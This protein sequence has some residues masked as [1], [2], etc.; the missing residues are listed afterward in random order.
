[1]GS[2]VKM[3]G[4]SI[5]L[6]AE[7]PT[8]L[9]PLVAGISVIL[10]VVVAVLWYGMR[11]VQQSDGLAPSRVDQPYEG[12]ALS[13]TPSGDPPR[14]LVTH[15]TLGLSSDLAWLKNRGEMPASL[16]PQSNSSEPI[17]A[18]VLAAKVFATNLPATAAPQ[19]ENSS[20]QE[21]M[22]V[23]LPPAE[24]LAVLRNSF[25][26]PQP[27]AAAPSPSGRPPRTAVLR[28]LDA[29]AT[30][31]VTD[32]PVAGPP[33]AVTLA[34]ATS[35]V[36]VPAVAPVAAPAPAKTAAPAPQQAAVKSVEAA[37]PA[38]EGKVTDYSFAD[39]LPASEPAAPAASGVTPAPAI[40]AR[41]AAPKPSRG[42][43]L[44]ISIPVGLRG[45]RDG[46]P[47][48][49][50]TRTS[51]VQPQG[52]IL[53]LSGRFESEQELILVNRQS[54]QQVRCQVVSAQ[55]AENGKTQLTLAFA[56]PAPQFWRISFPP[57]E[58]SDERTPEA[59]EERDAVKRPGVSK[60]IR[61]LAAARS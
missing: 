32:R 44:S 41:A 48:E 54:N 39:F 60:E 2:V 47:F 46:G 4:V 55:P 34:P 31:A 59:S 38:L 17:E 50:E 1:M 61:G 9:I 14:R 49:M 11:R 25:P 27:R 8:E 33:R 40:S 26:A 24:K 42:Q 21:K 13:W 30:G 35:I 16:A 28:T 57:V 6:P 19:A 45:K 5:L 12:P 43:R 51:V 23:Q 3:L 18:L 36:A 29:R 7:T 15:D 37:R 58:R 53:N 52:A 22:G 56:D 20:R 10:M